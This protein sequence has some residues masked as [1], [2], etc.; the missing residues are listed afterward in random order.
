MTPSSY[1]ERKRNQI[2]ERQNKKVSRPRHRFPV[3]EKITQK[4]V[5][6]KCD[7]ALL[8]DTLL[9]QLK[10]LHTFK[11]AIQCENMC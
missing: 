6:K 5:K 9:Y 4:K 10:C 7:M 1:L 2:G 8:Y 11:S 3:D